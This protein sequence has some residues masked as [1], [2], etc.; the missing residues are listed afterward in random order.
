MTL[1]SLYI[2]LYPALTTLDTEFCSSSYYKRLTLCSH[3]LT[4]MEFLAISTGLLWKLLSPLMASL[5]MWSMSS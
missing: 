3:K 2:A 4:C 1:Y 5:G